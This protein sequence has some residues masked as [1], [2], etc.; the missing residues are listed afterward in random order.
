[1]VTH[2]FDEFVRA[3]FDWYGWDQ[4]ERVAEVTWGVLCGQQPPEG[5]WSVIKAG[6]D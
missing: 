1:M 6:A 2:T 4:W 5:P 3:A